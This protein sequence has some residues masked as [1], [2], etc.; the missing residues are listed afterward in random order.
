M[1]P[2]YLTK[3]RFK[4][5]LDC[6]TKL[7]YTRKKEYANKSESDSFLEALAQGGF[8]VEELARMDYPDGIAIIGDDY[9][10]DLLAEKT[11]NLLEQENITIFEPAFLI[12]DLFIRVDMLVKSGNN[13][14][15]IEVKAKS[16][17]SV[18][19]ESFIKSN[20]QLGGGWDLYLYDIAFQK[21][22]IQSSYPEWNISSYL[23]LADKDATTTVDGLHQ[24]FKVVS[25]SDLR[26]GI[27]KKEGI[28]KADLGD[29]ILCE[30]NV[31]GEI[32]L[33][34]NNNPLDENRSFEGTVK[35]Y[36]D[37]YKNDVKLFT[38]IGT[39]CK[40]CEFVSE[41]YENGFKSGFHECW[42]KQ[43]QLP[44]EKID[45]PKVYDV[46]YNP[47]KNAIE[48]DRY[49]MEE[50]TE[51]D[52]NI[53]SEA[54]KMSRSE[55]QW[56]QI[57]KHKY[58]DDSPYFD[59]DNLR[60]ELDSWKFPLNFIDFETTAVAI[61]FIAGMHP[62]EQLAFQFSHHIVYEDGTVDHFNEYLN[63]EIGAFPNFDFIR[64]LKKSLSVNEGSI[65]RYHN[66]E[67]TI[68]NVIYNQLKN[69]KEPDKEELLNFIRSIS[70]STNKNTESWAGDRDMIDLQKTVVN[71]YYDPDTGGSNS[72]KAI[73]PAVLRSSVYLQERY[74]TP[75][76]KL[77]L[78]SKNF[79]EDHIFLMF[80][81]G[82]PVNPY[83]AL[84]SVFDGWDNEK[85]EQVSES[86]TEIKDG[87]AALFAYQKLQF[88]DV[89]EI[90]RNAIQ[91]GLLRYCE[92]D[93]LAMV[94]IYEYF[95]NVCE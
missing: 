58:A 88:D 86:L 66:H 15:L 81:N 5:A 25:D 67:N 55:R 12:N 49:F 89:P 91:E 28:T 47:A 2:R 51:N 52:L 3:S 77:N 38:E 24:C 80:E 79:P 11:R 36:K 23:K 54:G 18:D 83:K 39:H 87:G 27:E 34:L 45:R 32:D 82:K 94:M 57:E 72:I 31:S 71:Y 17:R 78:S 90:E 40:G 7:Y 30:I 9:N 14:K 19:H 29:S 75:L 60:Q 76:G 42:Q 63:T 43:L 84:P 10:Y 16:I 41:N 33:I 69:S 70:H 68:V 92:L 59:I 93:T 95:K 13:I 65:F 56:L 1:N 44:K 62:Y 46:W 26:T 64:A 8:Q 53:R 20:G 4:L 6:P 37:H 61:P 85:L 35:H 21:Y 50:L 73:L 74:Q 48:E 22:V